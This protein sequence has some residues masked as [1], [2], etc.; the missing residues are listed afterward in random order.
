MRGQDFT[1]PTE[2]R[3][4]APGLLCADLERNLMEERPSVCWNR[5]PKR[6]HLFSRRPW[7]NR[8]W[9]SGALVF[10]EELDLQVKAEVKAEEGKS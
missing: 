4:E 3:A 10:R 9:N 7:R 6:T 8:P 5:S 1:V 2:A